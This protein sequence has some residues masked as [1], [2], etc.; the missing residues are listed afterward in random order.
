MATPKTWE[1]EYN[2]KR[3]SF[4]K[5]LN[6]YCEVDTGWTANIDAWQRTMYPPDIVGFESRTVSSVTFN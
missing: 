1:S 6:V 3:Y 5:P 2:G 4:N